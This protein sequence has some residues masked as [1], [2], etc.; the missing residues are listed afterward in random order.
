MNLNRLTLKEIQLTAQLVT[1]HLKRTKRKMSQLAFCS[2]CN[3]EMSHTMT[4]FK[5][6]GGK[7]QNQKICEEVMSVIVCIC[8]KC[9][10]ID[11]RAGEK[12]NEN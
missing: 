12:A 7:G 9:G 10:K 11:L 5:I 1:I 8:P 6:E 4:R 2:L 3:V